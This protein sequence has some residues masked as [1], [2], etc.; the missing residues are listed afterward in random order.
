MMRRLVLLALVGLVLACAVAT[1]SISES[2]AMTIKRL[3]AENAA[4]RFQLHYA[5]RMNNQLTYKIRNL[6]AN[7]DILFKRIDALNNEVTDLT[8]LLHQAQSDITD[9]VS[10]LPPPVGP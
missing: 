6:L 7:I 5:R 9:C 4:L 3:R 8:M 10:K 2:P 1:A